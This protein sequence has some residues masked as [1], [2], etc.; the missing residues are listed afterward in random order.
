[1]IPRIIHQVY[2]IFDDG[3]CIEEIGIFHKNTSITKEF[4]DNNNIGYQLWDLRDSEILIDKYPEYKEIW[5]KFRFPIQRADF[6]RYLILYDQGGI[7]VDCDIYPTTNIDELFLKEQF[8]VRW[9]NDS[10]PYNAVLGSIQQNIVYKNIINNCVTDTLRCQSMKVYDNWKGRLVF[11]TTGHFG[12][13]RSLKQSKIKKES[14]LD[15]LEIVNDMKGHRVVG[16][17][18]LFYD[19]NASLWWDTMKQNL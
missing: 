14:F 11:Q 13:M 7:Y 17:N 15:I 18:P 16:E 3:I 12:L 8:F 19:E 5:N 2:G 10:K 9:N 4:C 6:I 1:M